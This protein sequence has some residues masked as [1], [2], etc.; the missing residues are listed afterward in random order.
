[1]ASQAPGLDGGWRHTLSD[2]LR[3]TA[4]RQV[5]KAIAGHTTDRMAEHKGH[6]SLSDR[7]QAAREVASKMLA[8]GLSL[9]GKLGKD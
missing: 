1:M 6:V 5:Q 2:L 7:A 4:G 3:K 9:D 8:I